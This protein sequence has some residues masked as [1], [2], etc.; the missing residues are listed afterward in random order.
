MGKNDF[1]IDFDFEKEYGFDPKAF[2]GTE[3]YDENIDLSEFSD[4]ELGLTPQAAPAAEEQDGFDLD[5]ELNSDDFLNLGNQEEESFETEEEDFAMEEEDFSE[6]EVEEEAPAQ[7]EAEDDYPDVMVFPR[8]EDPVEY[9]EEE[10]VVDPSVFEDTPAYNENGEAYDQDDAAYAEDSSGY[11]EEYD[12]DEE[13]SRPHREF[14]LPKINLPKINMPKF[15]TPKIFIKFYDLYFAPVL[16]K[17]LREEPRDPNNPRRR[18]KKSKIQVFKEVYLP[19]IIACVCLILVLSF[20]IG[21][22]SNAI[23]VRRAANDEKDKQQAAASEAASLVEEEYQ[24]LMDGAQRLAA[25]Y[26]YQGAVDLIDSF[27]G[28]ITKYQDMVALRAEYVTAQTQL[29][30]HRDPSLIP[31]LSFHVLIEDLDRALKDESLG[32]KYNRN[33]VSTGEFKQ[34]LEHLYANGYVLVD[35]NSFIEARSFNDTEQFITNPIY[36]PSGKKPVMITETM[37]NYFEYMVDPDK[38]GIPDAKGA[39]FAN[40]LVVEG[41]E[42]KAA[43]VDAS[44]NNLV[45]D[46]DLVPILE[47]FIKEHPDFSYR[48]ARAILAVTGSE[49]IFGYRINTSNQATKGQAWYDEE[50]NAAREVVQTLRNKGYTLACFTYSNKAYSGYTAAQIQAEMQ[51]WTK[52]ITPVIGQIDTFVFAQESNL[53]AYSGAAFDVLHNTGFRYFISSGTQPWAAVESNY[54]RQNRLMVTG[55]TM[56]HYSDQFTGMFDCAAILNVNLRGNVPN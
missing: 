21:S 56:Q 43:Y 38:D 3:E 18:R 33:F 16:N 52:N 22:L 37:V 51:E 6:D 20:A 44:G 10:P 41:G 28:D 39:G 29:T 4:E 26:D 15:T 55:R 17:E 34:I 36:L 5:E 45:G 35:F 11:D 13:E 30:E 8:R 19:P 31:N 47:S 42:I 48:G 2:L 7:T 54:V 50:C 40:K 14:K 46:Y 49:G 27:S 24:A 12:E 1:D 23:E 9:T 53:S 25:G 32:G